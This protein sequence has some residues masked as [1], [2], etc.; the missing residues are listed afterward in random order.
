MAPKNQRWWL[1]TDSQETVIGAP[2]ERVYDLIADITRMGEWSNECARV[3]WLDGA[4]APAPGAR[5]LGHNRTG[6]AG[7]IKWSRRGRV[8]TA[9]RGREFAFATEEGGKE[10]VVWR[11]RFESVDGGTRVTESYTVSRIPTWAR[12]VDVPTN[13]HRALLASMRHTLA[14]LKMTAEA[15]PIEGKRS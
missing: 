5:F 13:R 9:E 2:A 14:Q 11:Y 12:I 6:P 4:T 1:T 3:E 7:I 10:G 8:L 15:A